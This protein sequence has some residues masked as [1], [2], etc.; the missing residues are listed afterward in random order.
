[1]DNGAL[2]QHSQQPQNGNAQ[3]SGQDA[4][5]VYSQQQHQ[6]QHHQSP[7]QQML[8]QQQYGMA[9]GGPGPMP[10]FL[11]QE[12]SE[13]S[14]PLPQGYL[15]GP[16][17][18]GYPPYGAGGDMHRGSVSGSMLPAPANSGFSASSMPVTSAVTAITHEPASHS[19]IEFG[20]RYQYVIQSISM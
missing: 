11:K 7:P 1:M 16:P 19:M 17:Q 4:A 3:Y 15:V 10:P 12:G 2:Y 13:S 18:Q 14:P 20:R 8:P 5:S 9:P 6:G